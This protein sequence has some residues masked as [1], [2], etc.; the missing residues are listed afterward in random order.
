MVY[1]RV[2]PVNRLGVYHIL[3]LLQEIEPT[4]GENLVKLWERIPAYV[5]KNSPQSARFGKNFNPGNNN[6]HGSDASKPGAQGGRPQGGQNWGQGSPQGHDGKGQWGGRG[7]YSRGPHG[8]PQHGMP[9]NQPFNP[10]YLPHGMPQGQMFPPQ[11][12]NMSQVMILQRG[13]GHGGRGGQGGHG[14]GGG[15]PN[16]GG[17][18]FGKGP[19]Q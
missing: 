18:Y 16:Q 11:G 12:Q 5:I 6:N 19:K 1:T 17:N 13:Q 2:I 4:V 8:S 14:G 3:L 15:Y 10:M 7:G 9:V